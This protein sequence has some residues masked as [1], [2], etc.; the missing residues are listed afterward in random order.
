MPALGV[1]LYGVVLLFLG[2]VVGGAGHGTTIFYDLSMSPSFLG[3]WVWVILAVLIF[4]RNQLSVFGIIVILAWQWG[5]V[6]G[7]IVRSMYDLDSIRQ[8]LKVFPTL[9]IATLVWVVLGNGFIVYQIF[10]KYRGC[11]CWQKP[12]RE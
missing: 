4:S 5:D 3:V 2:M 10:A 11:R 8:S 12:D 7:R 9:L 1:L 6:V